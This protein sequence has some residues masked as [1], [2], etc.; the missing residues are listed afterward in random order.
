MPS[1]LQHARTR[2]W[3]GEEDSNPDPF[4]PPSTRIPATAHHRPHDGRSANRHSHRASALF[5]WW[6]WWLTAETNSSQTLKRSLVGPPVGP[7]S[8]SIWYAATTPAPRPDSQLLVLATSTD[9]RDPV[10]SAPPA[11][12]IIPKVSAT[13]RRPSPR[14]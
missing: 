4:R 11:S 6:W 14:H 2:G 9:M 7:R 5:A 8:A 1:L 12:E 10:Y 3:S 13:R